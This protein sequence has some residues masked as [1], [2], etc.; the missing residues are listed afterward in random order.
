MALAESRMFGRMDALERAEAT[1]EAAGPSRGRGGASRQY[2]SLHSA[3]AQAQ[4]RAAR[5]R[6]GGGGGGAWNPFA[7]L[8]LP[9]PPPRSR[10]ATTG[11]RSSRSRRWDS[12][13]SFADMMAEMLS[14]GAA[15]RGGPGGGPGGRLG[16]VMAELAALQQAMVGAQSGALPPALLF[17]DRCARS[18]VVLQSSS[19][20]PTRLFIAT[21][22]LERP[23]AAGKPSSGATD[24]C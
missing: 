2:T 16:A 19:L 15:G 17:S 11:P 21:G 18:L 3:A 12:G 24:C 9:L 14:M 8:P 20:Q 13:S 6:G 10:A 7:G 5:P 23:R 22:A 1:S 4:G